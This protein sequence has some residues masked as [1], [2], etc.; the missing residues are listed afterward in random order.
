M[1]DM[2]RKYNPTVDL[3]KFTSNQKILSN[4]VI[5]DYKQFCN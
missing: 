2:R 3:S 1:E 5:L 4:V